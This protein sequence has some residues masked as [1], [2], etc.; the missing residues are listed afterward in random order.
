M[1]PP[2]SLCPLCFGTS[3][4]LTNGVLVC[5]SC[6]TQSQV[7]VEEAQEFQTGIDD[8]RF[9]Q[10]TQRSKAPVVKLETASTEETPKADSIQKMMLWYCRCLQIALQEVVTMLQTQCGQSTSLSSVVR[11]ICNGRLP[12]L[13][14]PAL[15][16]KLLQSAQEADCTLP[17]ALL[18][19]TGVMGVQELVAMAAQ[20]GSRLQMRLPPVNAGALLHRYVQDLSLP[21]EIVPVALR[22]FDIYLSGSPQVWLQDDVFLHPYAHLM[23]ILLVTLKLCCQLDIPGAAPEEGPEWQAWARAVLQHTQGPHAFP[24]TALEAAALSD[25]DFAAYMEYLRSTVFSETS[26]PDGLADII[27]AV[28]QR[29]G[30]DHKRDG[31]GRQPASE[32]SHKL[33]VPQIE[34]GIRT[35][36][37]YQMACVGE[38]SAEHRLGAD[39]VAVLTACAAHLWL[40]PSF[41]H[42]LVCQLELNMGKL[43]SD[44]AMSDAA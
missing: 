23:A 34:L 3:W 5:D 41:L 22:L 36:T 26:V 15:S 9:R 44:L 38:A 18:Q 16:A 8:S 32:H 42:R 37:L 43:E 28:K 29:A 1:D 40:Q 30:L 13:S 27:K 4:S 19:P 7:Y 31:A 25:E 17:P 11:R 6:G 20:I 12:F 10:R 33:H 39:Y 24:A 14:L 21:E 35:E 2:P